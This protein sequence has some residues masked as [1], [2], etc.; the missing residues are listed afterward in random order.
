MP[1]GPRAR[2]KGRSIPQLDSTIPAPAGQGAT[3]RRKCQSFYSVGMAREQLD[4]YRWLSLIDCPQPNTSLL[5]SSGEQTPIGTP[6]DRDHRIGMQQGLKWRASL[7]L[8]ELDDCIIS[9]AGKHA[10][11]GSERHD[12]DM[13]RMSARPEQGA[14]GHIPEL[15]SAIPAQKGGK[16]V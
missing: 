1:A 6:G 12:V 16:H 4:T 5:I 11:I 7:Y 9:G 8:Q 2:S 14:A 15:H 10:A 3:I 13:A